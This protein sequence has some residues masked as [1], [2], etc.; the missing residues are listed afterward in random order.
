MIDHAK[1]RKL[2][3]GAMANDPAAAKALLKLYR[4]G[5]LALEIRPGRPF[6]NRVQ[7]MI[8]C[9]TAGTGL[10][11][12]PAHWEFR[13]PD[14]TITSDLLNDPPVGKVSRSVETLDD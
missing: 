10:T 5:R 6:P 7:R 1:L 8:A 11:D 2:R 4:R 9:L 12:E 13:H 3:Q 14:G